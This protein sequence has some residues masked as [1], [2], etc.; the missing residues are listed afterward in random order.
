MKA[1][2]LACIWKWVYFDKPQFLDY[3]LNWQC[4]SVCKYVYGCWVNGSEASG[5]GLVF[6]LVV[7][8]MILGFFE[9]FRT[10]ESNFAVILLVCSFN[11][12][13]ISR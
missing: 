3:V 13:E 8:Y 5:L 6:L 7:R 10:L 9:G 11:C 4:E 2:F 12:T 1:L